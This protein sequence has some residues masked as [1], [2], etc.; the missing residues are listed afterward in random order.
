MSACGE[1]DGLNSAALMQNILIRK[2]IMK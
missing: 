2:Y 1:H